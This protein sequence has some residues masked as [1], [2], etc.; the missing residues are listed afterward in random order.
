MLELLKNFNLLSH[1]FDI[2]VLLSF[3]LYRFDGDELPSEFPP[4]L[5]DLA[6]RPL[7]Y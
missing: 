1:S 6:I 3:F 5:I 4:G 7:P 2:L